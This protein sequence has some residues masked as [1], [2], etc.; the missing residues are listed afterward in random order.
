MAIRAT[1]G[2]APYGKGVLEAMVELLA[3]FI[4]DRSGTRNAWHSNNGDEPVI[5][6]VF[7]WMHID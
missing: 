2:R 5:R 6:R 3:V 7:G 4:S 1:R